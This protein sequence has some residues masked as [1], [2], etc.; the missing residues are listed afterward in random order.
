MLFRPTKARCAAVRL[1]REVRAFELELDQAC[2]EAVEILL[3]DR[4]DI[5]V[6]DGRVRALVFAPF[7]RNFVRS[8]DRN[9]RQTLSQ[10]FGTDDFVSRGEV[11]VQEQHRDC[12]NSLTPAD[13]HHGIEVFENKWLEDASFGVHAFAHFKAQ[14]TRNKRR[15]LDVAKIVQVGAVATR[16]LED[17]AK[18]SGRNQCS[19]DAL[20]FRYRVNDGRAAVDKKAYIAARD[21]ALLDGVDDSLSKV[22]G[23]R[24]RLGYFEVAGLF[25]E[26]HQVGEGPADVGCQPPH[27]Q[28]AFRWP[29]SAAV[30]PWSISPVSET[31]TP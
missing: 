22:L 26:I 30:A 25:I 10:L 2:F 4:L 13:V 8:S 18:A 21:L 28:E 27:F 12:L 9:A 23:S 7:P 11:T 29:R 19:L 5:R 15:L 16:N 17:V 20:A 6:E 3:D 24:Q 31:T 14:R 1:H